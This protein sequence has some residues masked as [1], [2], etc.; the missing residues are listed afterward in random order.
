MEYLIGFNSHPYFRTIP[1]STPPRL[2]VRSFCL[3][4]VYQTLLDP[5]DDLTPSPVWGQEVPPLVLSTDEELRDLIRELTVI[6]KRVME[7]FPANSVDNFK[8]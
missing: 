6:H 5:T 1:R 8:R 7:Q 3:P 2:L 4:D